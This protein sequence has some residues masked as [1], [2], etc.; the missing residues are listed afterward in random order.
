[1]ESPFQEAPSW[2]GE[3][4]ALKK[5]HPEHQELKEPEEQ[6]INAWGEAGG[7]QERTN[8]WGGGASAASIQMGREWL[9]PR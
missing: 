3:H 5:A 4:I 6:L 2:K 9:G 7:R 1:M 8:G